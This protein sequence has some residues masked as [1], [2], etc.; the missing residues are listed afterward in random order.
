VL[1]LGK[2]GGSELNFSSDVDLVYLHR[3]DSGFVSRRSGSA[4]LHAHA[5]ALGRRVTAVLGEASH[6]G[7]VY[8]VDLRLRPEG[9]AGAISHSLRAAH[10]Y[11][12]TRGASWERL[13]LI[14]A[15]PVA[16]DF[17]LARALL[18][19][20]AAFVWERPFDAQALHQVLRMKHESDRRLAARGLADRHVKLGRGGIREIELITQVLQL[21]GGSR[22]ALRSRATLPAL[23]ALR[24]AGALQAPE[25]DALARAYLFLRDVE[26]KLQM[27]HDAQT[28]LLPAD[29]DELRLLARRLGY[30][31]GRDAPAAAGF[32]NDLSG[33]ADTVN[34]LFH[35]LLLRPL[36]GGTAP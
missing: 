35:D 17:E 15:R 29:D 28:H 5:G 19:R 12:N 23:A 7:H 10:E 3:T 11:Y 25:A 9:R 4:T 21:R 31:D 14:K 36:I 13:A 24:E 6:E 1:A 22:G 16:G 33:H 20:V 34:R 27:V 8:R 30:P 2:L 32:R 26:N 18:R